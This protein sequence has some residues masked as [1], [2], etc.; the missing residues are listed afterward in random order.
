MN[1]CKCDVC[2]KEFYRKP[3]HIKKAKG[4]YC[5]KKC[6]YIAKKAYM[7]GGGNH[8]FGLK[9]SK[10]ATW[11]SDVRESSYGY[12]QIR[13]LD[14]PFREKDDF[15]FEHRLVAEKYLLT[16]ENSVRINGKKYL[17]PGFVV[18]HKNFDRKDNRPENLEVLTFSEHQKLH[19][20]LNQNKRNEK[21]QFVKDEPNTIRVK[22]VTETAIVP[23]RKTIGAAGF[24]LYAD[25]SEPVK[26]QPHETKLVFSGIAFEI[27]KNYFGAIYA[28]SGMSV[29]LGLRPATCVSVIDSDYRGNIGL[30][31]HND[32][33]MERVILPH[34]R[35]AQIVFQ[36]ALIVDLEVVNE[37]DETDRGEKGFGSTGV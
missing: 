26:I 20:S 22:R 32:S 5:S 36:K 2:G 15:V 29:S 8:Q 9:G 25:I 3:S 34:E 33:E 13:C 4:H 14:H 1:N 12:I 7:L 11:Q 24:D 23:E 30:P 31:I 16:S 19:A 10:N 21:G 35:V 18:H 17:K 37:L 28:R 27:P 6:H